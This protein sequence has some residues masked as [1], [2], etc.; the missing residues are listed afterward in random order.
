MKKPHSM[1]RRSPAARC[2]ELEITS[3]QP[4]DAAAVL[5]LWEECNLVV[6]WNDPRRDIERKLRLQPELFLVARLGGELVASLMAGY[7][8]HRGWLNYLAVAPAFR[9][10]GIGRRMVAQ[11][12]ERLRAMGCPKINLQVRRSNTA[13]MEFYRRLGFTPDDVVSMG[14]RLERDG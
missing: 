3:F 14:K 2:R 10:Q 7:E 8:G 6:P 5:R 9:R 4:G 13:V 12:E 11:A 1:Q